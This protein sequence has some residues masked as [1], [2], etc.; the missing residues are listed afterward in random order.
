MFPASA[1][2]A[3]QLGPRRPPS[4]GALFQVPSD[5]NRQLHPGSPTLTGTSFPLSNTSELLL[6]SGLV[7]GLRCASQ[8][9][10]W[11]QQRPDEEPAPA[12]CRTR[13]G[14]WLTTQRDKWQYLFHGHSGTHM[15]S[16]SGGTTLQRSSRPRE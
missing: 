4:S 3:F 6:K 16:S 9:S 12:F 13:T 5:M 10:S 2:H 1:A 14:T 7:P 11:R 8:C 15:V